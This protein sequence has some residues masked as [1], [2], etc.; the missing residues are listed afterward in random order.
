MRSGR[1]LLHHADVRQAAEAVG[2][3]EPVANE[4]F[5]AR[6]EAD[7]IGL[8]RRTALRRLVEKC[9]IEAAGRLIAIVR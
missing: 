1:R 5:V 8:Q 7:E 2:P 6:L 9:E 4:K 3:V